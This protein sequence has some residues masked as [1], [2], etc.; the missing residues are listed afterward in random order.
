MLINVTRSRKI[1]HNAAPNQIVFIALTDWLI[2]QDRVF[3]VFKQSLELS[4]NYNTKQ[5]HVLTFVL[6]FK[7]EKI[8]AQGV[9]RA[10]LNT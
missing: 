4:L 2:A 10:W 6:L 7:I 9:A 3:Q 8:V 5:C 1:D